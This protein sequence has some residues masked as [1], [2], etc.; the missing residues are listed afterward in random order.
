MVSAASSFAPQYAIYDIVAAN[1]VFM[2]ESRRVVG[3]LVERRK[4]LGISQ[5][6]AAKALGLLQ[7]NISRLEQGKHELQLSTALRF[8]RVLG[9]TIDLCENGFEPM[10]PASCAIEVRA[11]LSESPPDSATAFRVVTE[12]VSEWDRIPDDQRAELVAQKPVTTRIAKFDAL[13]S[14]VVEML[15]VRSGLNPPS[16]VSDLEYFME[17]FEW[18]TPIPTLEALAMANTPAPLAIRG[19]FVDEQSLRS[20]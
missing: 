20:V 17:R 19:I 1:I 5:K 6:E 14:G 15:C 9:T 8:A 16:W 10:T 7:S 12:L 11:L 13:I 18:F 2:K 3:K 4:A